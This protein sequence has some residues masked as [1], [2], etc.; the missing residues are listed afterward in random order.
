MVSLINTKQLA[1]RKCFSKMLKYFTDVNKP[2]SHNIYNRKNRRDILSMHNLAATTVCVGNTYQEIL[3]FSKMKVENDKAGGDSFDIVTSDIGFA[4]YNNKN[5]NL[6]K[7]YYEDDRNKMLL[8]NNEWATSRK[9]STMSKENNIKNIVTRNEAG[10]VLKC[11]GCDKEFLFT[12]EQIDLYRHL[13]YDTR[14]KLCNKCKK[15]KI[16]RKTRHYYEFIR[17]KALAKDIDFVPKTVKNGQMRKC[18]ACQKE[19]LFENRQIEFF[20][21]LKL[22][23]PL[24]CKS[25][26]QAKKRSNAIQQIKFD[27]NGG[28]KD[29]NDINFFRNLDERKARYKIS[30]DEI[31]VRI[32]GTCKLY[33]EMIE[34]FDHM[35]TVR[36]K[37]GK[38]VHIY[39]YNFVLKQLGFANEKKYYQEMKRYYNII[40]SSTED[41]QPTLNTFNILIN[42]FSNSDKKTDHT[43]YLPKLIDNMQTLYKIP[44]DIKT[45]ISLIILYEKTDDHVNLDYYMELLK[46]HKSIASGNISKKVKGYLIPLYTELININLE[47]NKYEKMLKYV[48]EILKYKIIFINENNPNSYKAVKSLTDALFKIYERKNLWKIKCA[49]LKTEFDAITIVYNALIYLNYKMH[50]YDTAINLFQ[51]LQ[52]N[53]NNKFINADTFNILLDHFSRE[54]ESENVI[55]YYDKMLNMNNNNNYSNHSLKPNIETHNIML[56]EYAKMER[57]EDMKRQLFDMI[58]VQKIHPNRQTYNTFISYYCI[59]G[60]VIQANRWFNHMKHAKLQPSVF[61]YNVLYFA[62]LFNKDYEKAD[63]LRGEVKRLNKI[64]NKR[65][66][67][68]RYDQNYV[69]DTKEFMIKD[70]DKKIQFDIRLGNYF[71]F[72]KI[73]TDKA[74]KMIVDNYFNK[75]QLLKFVFFDFQDKVCYN[76]LTTHYL[77]YGHFGN[78]NLTKN[79]NGNVNSEGNKSKESHNDSDELQF[80]LS[81]NIQDAEKEIDEDD[82]DYWPDE[83]D[84]N[85]TDEYNTSSVNDRYED[86]KGFD[87]IPEKEVQDDSFY[88]DSSLTF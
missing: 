39:A 10:E 70:S 9:F 15:S 16:K 18:N 88:G 78:D 74:S 67:A 80:L 87:L 27:I 28:N 5:K 14:P 84:E 3:C 63:A 56:H 22:R 37:N 4:E 53:S 17:R 86:R 40:T 52:S 61:T 19:Y 62:Y 23:P 81:L 75:G 11:F 50:N 48:D 60:D 25:C 34:K 12:N 42:A 46:Q 82:L 38:I 43:T 36:R 33:D 58:N 24:K 7:A 20:R 35:R 55:K 51:K 69:V 85:D 30:E 49:T 77:R 1:E 31:E 72:D 45:C 83:I 64:I 26:V 73:K 68:K 13:D 21:R 66:V 76:L 8:T 6:K 44:L 32:L 2:R 71:G 65:N 41:V 54:G 59:N 47:R 57:F 79:S 29:K